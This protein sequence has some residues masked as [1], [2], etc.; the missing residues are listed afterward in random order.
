MIEVIIERIEQYVAEYP[1]IHGTKTRW[2]KPLVAFADAQDEQFG[3]LKSIVHPDH[4]MPGDILPGARTVVSYFLPFEEW[5]VQSNIGGS[6]S[7]KEWDYAYAQTNTL[8]INLNNHLVDS[9][10]KDG[11]R[12]AFVPPELV[13][14][15]DLMLSKWSLRHI[16]VIA[17]LGTFGLNNMLITEKGCCGRTNSFVT[18]LVLPPTQSTSTQNCLFKHDGSC[19]QC[20][21][22]CVGDAL[23]N[24]GFN[25]FKC[26]SQLQRNK[27][28]YEDIGSVAPCG[29]CLVGLP[30]SVAN[31][32]K[33]ERT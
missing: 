6:N 5:I 16:A 15:K 13:F 2:C 7:S 14:D 19:G 25:R 30:C 20:L 33:N 23:S 27:K 22:S 21:Q 32:V 31:P 1:R 3:S 4:F 28:S 29:K 11:I 10:Q 18:E 26:D 12:A 17:H 8:F 24:E 9:L